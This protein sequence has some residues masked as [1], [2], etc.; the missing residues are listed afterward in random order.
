[1]KPPPS[2][3]CG[4]NAIACSTPLRPSTCSPTRSASDARCSGSVASSSSTGVSMPRRFAIR[5]TRDTRPYPV[6]RTVAPSAR[7]SRA[8][9]YAIDWSVMTPVT[10]RRLPVI[11]PMWSVPHAQA[12]VDRDDRTVHVARVVARQPGD[13][14]AD[15][16]GGGHPTGRDGLED[17]GLAVV[18]EHAGH[19]GLDEP[20]CDNVRGH[21]A[22]AELAGDGAGQAHQAGLAGRVVHLPWPAVEADDRRH[23]DH[24]TPPGAHHLGGR[25]PGTTP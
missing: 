12:A 24:P 20:R 22:G 3:L 21:V 10:S 4:P 17:L 9:E 16:V 6:S 11:S 25:A 5:S 18:G 2:V 15:L 23:E 13:D 7:A 14:R 8:T 19:V 1:M